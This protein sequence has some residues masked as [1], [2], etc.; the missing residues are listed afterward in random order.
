MGTGNTLL[1]RFVVGR[2]LAALGAGTS[3]YRTKVSTTWVT[4]MKI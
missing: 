2:F 3:T 1:E 4:F